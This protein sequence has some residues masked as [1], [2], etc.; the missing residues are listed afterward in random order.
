MG[1]TSPSQPTTLSQCPCSEPAAHW[2][3]PFQEIN[4]GKTDCLDFKFTVHISSP[5]MPSNVQSI[6]TMC[7]LSL[8]SRAGSSRSSPCVILRLAAFSRPRCSDLELT[9]C[10]PNKKSLEIFVVLNRRILR[11][12]FLFVFNN[13]QAM[14]MPS[15]MLFGTAVG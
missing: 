7:H 1:I 13:A 11:C 3:L 6:R 4:G 12:V 2:Q 14:A 15:R 9:T 8:I 10:F 5:Q